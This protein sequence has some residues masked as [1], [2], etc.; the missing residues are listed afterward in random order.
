MAHAYSRTRRKGV[1]V[2]IARIRKLVRAGRCAEAYRAFWHE[3]ADS[4]STAASSKTWT[5]LMSSISRCKRK[6]QQGK[7]R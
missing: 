3:M 2:G 4:S 7:G 5:R 1:A 6:K